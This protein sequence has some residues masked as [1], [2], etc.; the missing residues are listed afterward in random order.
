[1]VLTTGRRIAPTASCV[2]NMQDITYDTTITDAR[3]TRL[4][5]RQMWINRGPRFVG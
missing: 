2:E 3:L 4:A 1:M 5:A